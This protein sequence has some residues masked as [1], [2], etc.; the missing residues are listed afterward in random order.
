MF[1][2][3]SIYP[4]FDLK[5]ACQHWISILRETLKI[6]FSWF[7]LLYNILKHPYIG[8]VIS[9]VLLVSTRTH[10]KVL[11]QHQITTIMPLL[12]G[13]RSLNDNHIRFAMFL[14]WLIHTKYIFLY[15]ISMSL[16]DDQLSC[17]IPYQSGW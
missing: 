10:K 15:E 13:V 8:V 6:Q 2:S 5:F 12:Q 4:C 1:Y 17:Q 7:A 14:H 11:L 16:S 9:T 3:F